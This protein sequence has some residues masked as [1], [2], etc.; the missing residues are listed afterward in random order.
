MPPAAFDDAPPQKK[1]AGCGDREGEAG[2][3]NGADAARWA[4]ILVGLGTEAE[5]NSQQVP[6]LLYQSEV[7]LCPTTRFGST[8]T[9]KVTPEIVQLIVASDFGWVV[10]ACGGCHS[11]L[12]RRQEP[13]GG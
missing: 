6:R 10:H 11:G 13:P 4:C 3:L 7:R 2:F 12:G 1:R 8:I 9:A 5:V